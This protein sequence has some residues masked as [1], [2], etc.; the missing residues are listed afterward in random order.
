MKNQASKRNLKDLTIGPVL[1]WSNEKIKAHIDAILELDGAKIIFGG[2][3]LLGHSIPS[4]Y[5]SYQPT[6][7]YVPLKHFRGPKK[8][9][10]LTTELFGPFQVVTE[11][12]NNEVDK[13]LKIMESIPHHLTAAVVSN[14]Q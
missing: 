8:L 12:G 5:G 6:A 4:C 14:D 13:V 1:S 7:I 11:Y 3:P 10:L 9:K 2:T